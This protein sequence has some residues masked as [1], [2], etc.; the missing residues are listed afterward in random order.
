MRVIH[1]EANSVRSKRLVSVASLAL[2]LAMLPSA[3]LAARRPSQATAPS[4][5]QGSADQGSTATAGTPPAQAPAL[6]MRIEPKAQQ[7]LDRTVQAL[8]GPAF[9]S[10]KTLTTHGRLYSLGRGGGGFVYFDGQVQYPDKRRLAYGT[11][12]KGAKPITVINNGD[13]GWEIDRMG[14]V[15]LDSDEIRQWKFANRYSLENILRVRIHEPGILVQTAGVDFVDNVS[16]DI[17]DIVDAQQTQIKLY[18]NK[19]T[20]LPVQ[21]EYRKWNPDINDWNEYSDIYSDYQTYQGIATPKRISRSRNGERISE[22]YR[23][24]ATYNET[25]PA[26]IFADPSAPK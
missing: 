17:L 24:S 10:F 21:I 14:M 9:M 23:D 18:I 6:P 19:Q 5:G 15:H 1:H 25:Y 16:V 4:A 3:V 13:Q 7:I 20:S 26:E 11:G 22:V 8:G 2:G 12:K